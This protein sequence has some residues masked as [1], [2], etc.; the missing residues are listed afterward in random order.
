MF[1]FYK[2]T[3]ILIL[4]TTVCSCTPMV[5]PDYSTPRAKVEKEWMSAEAKI[6]KEETADYSEWWKT[7]NDPVLDNLI[8]E[9]YNQNLSLRIAGLRVIRAQ[10][11]RGI[12]IG[13]LF[14]QE[15]K[16]SGSY[17]EI[18]T[19]ENTTNLGSPVT[20]N[21]FSDF[22][23]G[24]DAFWELDFWGKFRRAVEA[25]N[26]ELVAS[27]ANYDDVLV[28]LIA[29]VAATYS[30]IRTFEK[31][32]EVTEKNVEIQKKT[33][34][35]AQ[36][37]F[38]NGLV[39]KLD[40]SQAQSL[41]N[42]TKS[43]IPV[44][45]SEI[46]GAK[47]TLCVLLGSPPHNI[48]TILSGDKTIPSPPAQIAV[49]IPAELLRRR[50]DIRKAERELAAQ[51][52]RIGIAEADLYPQ[53]TLNGS[54]GIRAEDFTDLFEGESLTGLISPGFEWPIFN[55]GR[56]RNNIRVQDAMFQELAENYEN[57]VLKAQ[58]EVENSITS[59]LEGKKRRNFLLDAVEASKLSVKISTTQYIDG[60]ISYNRLLDS[61]QFL[62]SQENLLAEA[63]GLV[64]LNLISLYKSLG[65][66]WEIRQGRAFI[67]DEIK[68]E[69]EKRTNWG[70]LLNTGEQ[71]KEIEEASSETPMGADIWWRGAPKW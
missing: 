13:E 66:G 42:D 10:A 3:A 31:R 11:S 23:V 12:S 41:L 61:Q 58:E 64:A 57:T 40:V 54:I 36:V 69:M 9:A 48:S 14:P 30:K 65:G 26:A 68:Q 20:K 50:P 7:F 1:R 53:F 39:S 46:Q 32:L 55:Y 24:F 67:P 62:V 15:Q 4:I 19:S 44:L 28:S 43:V 6:V 37:K 60:D 29:E 59:F 17:S 25:A 63:T 35:I 49:G 52:A 5:G 2:L 22:Q 16:I 56:I 47:N 45:E 8:E 21:E 27:V 38:R 18:R 34:K 51:S 70:N 33:L 71:Y